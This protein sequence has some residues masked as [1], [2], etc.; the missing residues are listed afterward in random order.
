MN[1][2]FYILLL[3]LAYWPV[4]SLLKSLNVTS[5]PLFSILVLKLK[6]YNLEHFVRYRE[7][8]FLLLMNLSGKNLQNKNLIGSKHQILE[9]QFPLKCLNNNLI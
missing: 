2:V 1:H 9:L 8:C 4:I 5:P 6:F 7:K 3:Q